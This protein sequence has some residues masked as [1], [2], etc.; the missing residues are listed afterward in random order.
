MYSYIKGKVASIELDR[1]VIENNGVGYEIF[2]SANTLARFKKGEEAEVYIY[3]Q[4]K[5]D[6]IALL[7]FSCREEK[8]MFLRL[9]TVSGIGPRS[10]QAILN[11]ITPYE[12]AYAIATN[13]GVK[14]SKVKGIGKKSA[15]RIIL[16][17]KEKINIEGEDAAADV[18]RSAPVGGDAE[19]A[20]VALQA[21]GFSKGDAF[22]AAAKAAEV[23]SGIEN[24]IRTALKLIM[25]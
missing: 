18:K 25:K 21:L 12:L 19:E 4:V 13:D 15:A 17:L 5:Q 22:A 6:G 1:V 3:F 8:N 2:V 16:E 9:I 10:A 11:E 20:A 24:I 7:G 14:L 23:A